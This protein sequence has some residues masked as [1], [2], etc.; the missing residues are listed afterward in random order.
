MKA[1]VAGSTGAIGSLL[2][3]RLLTDDRFAEIIAITR[4]PLTIQS[5]KLKELK[6]DSLKDLT[7]LNF[8]NNIDV[9]FCCLGTTIKTAGSQEKFRQVDFGGVHL[10]GQ[11]AERLRVKRFILISAMGANKNSHIFYNQV[12]G[13]AEA[14]LQ[15]RKIDSIII[16]RPGLLLVNRSEFRLGELLAIRAIDL[17]EKIIPQNFLVG[18]STKAEDLVQSMID[19]S[20]GISQEAKPSGLCFIEASQIKSRN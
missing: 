9:I 11:L 8:E 13:E 17:V 3:S 19:A 4:R 5:A 2:L 15:S 20:L 6:I 12:K 16:F 10:L 7:S 14:D 1:L 18:F